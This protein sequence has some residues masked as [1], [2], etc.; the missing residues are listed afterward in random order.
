M[1]RIGAIVLAVLLIIPGLAAAEAPKAPDY[2]LEGYDGDSTGRVWE[3]NLFFERMEEQTGISFQF[4]EYSSYSNWKSRKEEIAKGNDLPDILF[5]A[6]LTPAETQKMYQA[7]VLIDLTPYL[8]E[9]APDFW[10]LLQEHPEWKE[11][12][13][14][15]DQKSGKD[16]I[17]A[18]PAFNS[19]QNNDYMWIN[20]KWLELLGLETPTTAEELTEVLRAFKNRDPNTNGKNDEVPLTFIGMWELRFL[21]HAY[22]IIDNDYYVSVRNGQVVS[23]LDTEENRAFLTWLHTLWEEGLLDHKGFSISDSM[24]TITDTNKAIP[25]GMMMAVTP[26]SVIPSASAPM[27]SILEPM[28]YDGKQV[29]RDLTGDVIRGTFAITSA[30]KEPEK[31]VSW[32]NVLYT[33]EGSRTA[34]YG[35]EGE[36][37]RINS[38]GSWEWVDDLSTVAQVILSTHTIGTGASAPGIALEDFQLHYGDSTTRRN[39]EMMESAK[40]FSMMPY[41]YVYMTE[42]D[43]A[44]IARIQKDLMDYAE[45]TMA[46]FVTGDL[47]LNDE[48]WKTFCDTVH[49]K[50]LDDSIAIWQKYVTNGD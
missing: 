32:V 7:G 45:L 22:G 17:A 9:Y 4:R 47:E 2:I 1:R 38:D 33:E 26:L 13:T 8:E 41:P 28:T 20:T 3:T 40:A 46:C 19:L 16:V 42:T 44:E 43:A 14:F 21:G 39:I 34:Q 11:A 36:E 15:R 18:L 23:A 48:N 27:Y 49:A 25:Y 6:E 29:Y 10:A 30:C 37:I 35:R 24:R 5:K 50:G 12:I 31:M